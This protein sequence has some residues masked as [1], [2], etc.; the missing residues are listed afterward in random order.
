MVMAYRP[1]TDLVLPFVTNTL[2]QTKPTILL[3]GSDAYQ[4]LPRSLLTERNPL[5]ILDWSTNCYHLPDLGRDLPRIAFTNLYHRDGGTGYGLTYR[6]QSG[7]VGMVGQGYIQLE[8]WCTV[9]HTGEPRAHSDGVERCGSVSK[10]FSEK[11][12]LG[13]HSI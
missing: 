13:R 6:S 7:W 4:T 11:I 1:R 12:F 9:A 10:R 8:W 2:L 5:V 3:G